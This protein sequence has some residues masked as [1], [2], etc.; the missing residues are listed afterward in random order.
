MQERVF[1]VASE[2]HGAPNK[3]LERFGNIV[4]FKRKSRVGVCPA[5]LQEESLHL[6]SHELKQNFNLSNTSCTCSSI[7]KDIYGETRDICGETLRKNLYENIFPR[8][9]LSVFERQSKGVSRGS[10]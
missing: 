1:R 5:T 8:N 3:S 4:Y 6:K 2:M 9:P 7:S 10:K